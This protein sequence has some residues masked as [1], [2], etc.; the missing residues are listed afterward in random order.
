MGVAGWMTKEVESCL[1]PTQVSG[2]RC[3]VA[4]TLSWRCQVLDALGL[5]CQRLS[6]LLIPLSV[7]P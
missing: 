7:S 5:M 2:Q 4:L 6:G 3:R 1:S